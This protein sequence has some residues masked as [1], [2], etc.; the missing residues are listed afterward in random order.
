MSNN[1]RQWFGKVINCLLESRYYIDGSINEW[2][3]SQVEIWSNA[4]ENLDTLCAKLNKEWNEWY[5][6]PI[7]LQF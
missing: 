7:Y 2:R 3:T 1:L 6:T 4:L 5:Q